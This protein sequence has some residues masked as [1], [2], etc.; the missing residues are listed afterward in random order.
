MVQRRR[1]TA[2]VSVAVTVAL[3][4]VLQGASGCLMMGDDRPHV[5]IEFGADPGQFEGLEVE[6]D[7]KVVGTLK[8]LGAVTRTGFA[9]DKGEHT[10]RVRSPRFSCQPVKVNAQLKLQKIYLMLEYA[11]SAAAGDQGPALSLRPM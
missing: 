1:W 10:V 6:L 5:V 8:K 3:L 4:V 7:G 2:A 11:E 9:V